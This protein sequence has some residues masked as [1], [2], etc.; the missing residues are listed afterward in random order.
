MSLVTAVG[1]AAC[2]IMTNDSEAKWWESLGPDEEEAID[3]FTWIVG[4][5][6]DFP[7]ASPE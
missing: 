4:P 2:D 5:E 6:P 1:A 3:K 7:P